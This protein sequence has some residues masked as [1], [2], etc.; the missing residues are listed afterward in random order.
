MNW[1]L[2]SVC[3]VIEVVLGVWMWHSSR[4]TSD[5]VEICSSR[6]TSLAV[7]L[8]LYTSISLVLLQQGRPG[9]STGIPGDANCVSKIT[10]GGTKFVAQG[11]TNLVV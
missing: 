6:Q 11:G 7:P 3:W 4:I 8:N 10:G 5:D 9:A 2:G 1:Y